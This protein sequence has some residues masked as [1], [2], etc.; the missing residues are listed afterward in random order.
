MTGLLYIYSTYKYTHIHMH[1][2]KH[3]Y[4]YKT[5]VQVLKSNWK[6]IN[7]TIRPIR[8]PSFPTTHTH[9]HTHTSHL[10][11]YIYIYLYIYIAVRKYTHTHI[12]TYKVQNSYW[13]NWVLSNSSVFTWAQPLSLKKSP[14]ES[15]YKLLCYVHWHIKI[16]VERVCVYILCEWINVNILCLFGRGY[17]GGVSPN[18]VGLKV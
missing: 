5:R 17:C 6:A 14:S 16:A 11:L 3:L 2:H 8:S 18:F 12:H 13:L 10:D 4:A 15:P 9:L 1:L 7:Q